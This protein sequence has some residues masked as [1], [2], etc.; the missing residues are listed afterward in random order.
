MDGGGGG[1]QEKGGEKNVQGRGGGGKQEKVERKKES[2]SGRPSK[3]NQL[4]ICKSIVRH[5]YLL[6]T[7]QPT[8]VL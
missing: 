1:K 8:P 3:L 4:S 6:S 5:R 7:N 2:E